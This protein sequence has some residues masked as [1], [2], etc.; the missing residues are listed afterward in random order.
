V[1]NRNGAVGTVSALMTASVAFT[2]TILE[3]R[4]LFY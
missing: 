4:K 2:K 3:I 1:A